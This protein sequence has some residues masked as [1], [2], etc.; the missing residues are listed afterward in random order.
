[1]SNKYK[2]LLPK[3]KP[4]RYKGKLPSPKPKIGDRGEGLRSPYI[5]NMELDPAYKSASGG[6][7]PKAEYAYGGK[8]MKMASYYSG[9]GTV[10]TGR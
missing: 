10:F 9:G 8:K 5:E 3:S 7:K 4:S 6:K 1:M 2:G